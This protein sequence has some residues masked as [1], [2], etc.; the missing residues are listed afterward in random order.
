MERQRPAAASSLIGELDPGA[1]YSANTLTATLGTA[2]DGFLFCSGTFSLPAELPSSDLSVLVSMDS[3]STGDAVTVFEISIPLAD[4]MFMR[5][6][7][8]TRVLS[9]LFPSVGP[10]AHVFRALCNGSLGCEVLDFR[11]AVIPF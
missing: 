9:D 5:T 4:P 2:G 8:M 10:G 3:M 6:S 7:G 11:L 1:G